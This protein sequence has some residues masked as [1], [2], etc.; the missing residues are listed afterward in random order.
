MKNFLFFIIFFSK[1]CFSQDWPPELFSHKSI[2]NLTSIKIRRY[3]QKVIDQYPNEK[4]G[5]SF[6]FYGLSNNSVFSVKI[7]R[8]KDGEF[9]KESILYLRDGVV[10]SGI[11]LTKKGSSQNIRTEDKDLLLHKIDIDESLDFF[12]YQIIGTEFYF[13]YKKNGD[14]KSTSYH[15]RS[16]LQMF[17]EEFTDRDRK[18]KLLYFNCKRC[19]SAPVKAVLYNKGKDSFIRYYR[20]VNQ[21]EVGPAGFNQFLNGFYIPVLID[22]YNMAL[23]DMRNRLNFPFVF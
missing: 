16:G 2:F 6:Y 3:F 13:E 4:K 11:V 14:N 19:N 22:N 18:T 8:E 17:V 7:L 15:I 9:L 23:E 12:S 5:D 10:L 21:V 20:S 1:V